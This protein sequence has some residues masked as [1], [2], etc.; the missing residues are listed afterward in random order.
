MAQ[1][2]VGGEVMPEHQCPTGGRPVADR[3]LAG[4]RLLRQNVKGQQDFGI[5]QMHRVDHSVHHMQQF[6]P[7]GGDQQGNVPRCVAGRSDGRD[8]VSTVLTR[9]VRAVCTN[10]GGTLAVCSSENQKS[11]STCHM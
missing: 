5:L 4:E 9:A 11:H 10:I 8:P 7:F 2:G 6:F 3:L 1:V